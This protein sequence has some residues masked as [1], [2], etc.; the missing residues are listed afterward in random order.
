[1][2]VAG[3][4]KSVQ[5]R[6]IADEFGYAWL[7]TGEFLRMLISGE[8]RKAMLAGELLSDKEIIELVR[9]IFQ[10]IDTK[11]EFILDGFP[12]TVQQADWLLNQMKHELLSITAVVHIV[13]DKSVVRERLI[14]R[15]RLDDNDEA[16]AKRFEEYE[17]TILPVLE[18]FKKAGVTVYDINGDRPIEDVH[19][20]I[21]QAL[22]Q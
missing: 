14:S 11:E 6:R 17:Q 10:M 15:G 19:A 22:S 16:I 18:D 8:R 13:A 7:S 2:G 12:R 5:G 20:D 4:G 21:R 3:V 9:K 1:M